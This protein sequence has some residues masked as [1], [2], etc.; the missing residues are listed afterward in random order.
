[1]ADTGRSETLTD[2]R[3]DDEST[4]A[5]ESTETTDATETSV[6]VTDTDEQAD[7]PAAAGTEADDDDVVDEVADLLDDD[8]DD[9]DE[10]EAP[11]R[12]WALIVATAVAVVAV[13]ALAVTAFIAPGFAIRPGSP[14]SVATQATSAL[15]T[16]D[17]AQ[18][19]AVSCRNQ[20][21]V[22]TN[23]FPPDAL[24][25]IQQAQPAGPPQLELDTQAR[26]PVDLTLS[27]QGQTQNLPADIVLG[28]TD[29]RW[30]MTGISQ[31]G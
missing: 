22:P 13:V 17:P 25:L 12:P 9:D 30:C 21:G 10:D 8:D 31:R 4:D 7:P 14:D 20:Q 6:E 23:P 3:A 2:E 15:A 27:A 28:V 29:G 11:E 1:M 16:K 26:A 24:A 19:D 18:L 5:T